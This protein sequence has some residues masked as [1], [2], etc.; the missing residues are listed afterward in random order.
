ML[1]NLLE[2]EENIILPKSAPYINKQVYHIY[3]IR[4]KNRDEFQ[5]YLLRNNIPTVIHYPI[6]IQETKPFQ[7]Q[8]CFDNKRTLEYAKDLIR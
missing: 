7:N 6:P 1:D 8:D 5:K 2:D 4:V 3:A